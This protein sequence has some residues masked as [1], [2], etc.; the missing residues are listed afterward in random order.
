MIEDNNETENYNS[1]I[2][3]D[4]KSYTKWTSEINLSEVNI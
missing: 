4:L 3:Y 1:V 2:L